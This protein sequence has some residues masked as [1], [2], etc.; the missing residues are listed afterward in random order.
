[1]AKTILGLAACTQSSEH[2][3]RAT[4]MARNTC[5]LRETKQ[6][7][8]W[9]KSWNYLYNNCYKERD[10]CMQFKLLLYLLFRFIN[11]HT[12]FAQCTPLG[13]W[14]IESL[15]WGLTL[16]CIDTNKNRVLL[17]TCPTGHHNMSCKFICHQ[18]KHTLSHTQIHLCQG[19][20]GL[21]AC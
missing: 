6:I 21:R 20:S 11:S 12:I 15:T 16:R 13:I 14:S 2:K 5:A 1:M 19:W 3:T 4:H 9:N 8:I 18:H 10:I 7:Y 17:W